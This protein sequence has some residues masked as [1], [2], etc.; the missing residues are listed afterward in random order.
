MQSLYLLLHFSGL[1]LLYMLRFI[2]D[3]IC[4]ISADKL[5][6]EKKNGSKGILQS[7]MMALI[8]LILKL[9]ILL[10]LKHRELKNG[11]VFRYNNKVL[12]VNYNY[13]LEKASLSLH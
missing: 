4:T 5:E 2:Q 9:L 12:D 11:G 10:F 13:I 8:M 3:F 1:H 6:K 7:I